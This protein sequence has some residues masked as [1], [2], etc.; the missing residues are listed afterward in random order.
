LYC[1]NKL[2]GIKFYKYF[3]NP[4]AYEK[5]FAS[6]TKG[7]A[8]PKGRKAALSWIMNAPGGRNGL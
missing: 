5:Y 2:D 6:A 8:S 4:K 3:S 7:G 1:I